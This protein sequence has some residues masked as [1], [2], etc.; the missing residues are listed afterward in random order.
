VGSCSSTTPEPAAG[1]EVVHE[2]DADDWDADAQEVHEVEGGHA[3]SG[4]P[5]AAVQA[6]KVGIDVGGVVLIH[7][8][9]SRGPP[10]LVPYC[11]HVL[12]MLADIIGGVNIHFI[13]TVGRAYTYQQS[14][15]ALTDVGILDV[16][17]PPRN[18]HP[19]NG[20]AEKAA[21]AESLGVTLM[22]DDRANVLRECARVGIAGLLFSRN[23]DAMWRWQNF[24]SFHDLVRQVDNWVA[25][26]QILCNSLNISAEVDMPLPAVELQ[27]IDG[28][29]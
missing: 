17:V 5:F 2:P 10:Q 19:T 15:T 16:L 21:V 6:T 3:F 13:T 4:M 25:V 12:Q 20:D 1:A 7:Q 23:G 28:V 9:Y 29:N 27:V 24:R 11:K 14:L 8:A 18:V 26:W 22:V